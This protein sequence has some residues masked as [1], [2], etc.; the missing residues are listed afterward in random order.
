MSADVIDLERAR[1]RTF[2]YWRQVI[3][4]ALD[5]VETNT[6][7]PTPAYWTAEVCAD[8]ARDAQAREIARQR[9]GA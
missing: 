4:E 5:E 1:R 9:A 3:D 8:L 2:A 7:R 6:G